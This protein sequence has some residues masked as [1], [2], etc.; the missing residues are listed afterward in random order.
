[1]LNKL[2]DFIYQKAN[3]ISIPSITPIAP[4]VQTSEQKIIS[5]FE[6]F[7][8]KMQTHENFPKGGIQ[9]LESILRTLK[10]IDSQTVSIQEQALIRKIV[11]KDLPSMVELYFSLPKAHAVSFILENG[12]TSKQTLIDKL[13]SLTKQVNTIWDESVV[14]KTALLLKKQ[15]ATSQPLI[16]KKD[17]FDL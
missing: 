7:Y 9:S 17:F 10:E 4:V 6:K 14:E 1:M 15:K 5:Q 12:K 11:E 13:I 16:T 8:I 3:E 2:K